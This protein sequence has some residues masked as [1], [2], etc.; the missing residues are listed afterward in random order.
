MTAERRPT[1]RI[2]LI[3]AA[4]LLH[5]ALGVG[6][7][8]L[9]PS[10]LGFPGDL[11]RAVKGPIPSDNLSIHD[12]P[13]VDDLL[14][15]N[16][17]VIYQP[18]MVVCRNPAQTLPVIARCGGI[19]HLVFVKQRVGDEL[20][21]ISELPRLESLFLSGCTFE[22]HSWS[23]LQ[24]LCKLTSLTITD[25]ALSDD[26]LKSMALSCKLERLDLSHNRAVTENGIESLGLGCTLSALQL[27]G[28]GVASL[29]FVE[30]LTSLEEID[31]TATAVSDDD[32]TPH[33]DA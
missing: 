27:C 29:Q 21:M 14:A 4:V 30:K 32:L 16:C 6:L 17:E 11:F 2:V 25:A 3:G 10:V 1:R 13:Y 22:L 7:A 5:T 15:N 23:I 33:L 8:N 9:R 19:Y 20:S 24:P 18:T 31:L 26:D 12:R 28:T